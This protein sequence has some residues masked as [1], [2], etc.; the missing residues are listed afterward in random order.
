MSSLLCF[1]RL[2]QK[3]YLSQILEKNFRLV[4]N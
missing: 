4:Y 3:R 2:P 1:V